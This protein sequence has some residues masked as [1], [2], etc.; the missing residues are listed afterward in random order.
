MRLK[1][2]LLASSFILGIIGLKAQELPPLSVTPKPKLF[3]QLEVKLFYGKGKRTIDTENTNTINADYS[4]DLS[5]GKELSFEASTHIYKNFYATLAHSTFKAE[6]TSGA[7]RINSGDNGFFIL[8]GEKMKITRT[9][10]AITYQKQLIKRSNFRYHIGAGIMRYKVE[11]AIN[12]R[13]SEGPFTLNFE[14]KPDFGPY[15]NVGISSSFFDDLHFHFRFSRYFGK[16]DK[17]YTNLKNEEMSAIF[18]YDKNYGTLNQNTF[19]LG[20]SW[21]FN[22]K[23]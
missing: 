23:K 5:R 19:Q 22:L 7:L 14:N 17:L 16:F 12:L 13:G 2:L 21:L 18:E 8:L 10:F 11:D 1:Y 9:S 15:F 6:A 3:S 20:I 4:E